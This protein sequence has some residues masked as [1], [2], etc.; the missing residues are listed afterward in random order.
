[1]NYW[2]LIQ[3]AYSGYARYLW[4]EITHPGWHSYF[5]WLIGVSAFF[6]ILEWVKP[7]RKSQARFRK[8]FWL[9]FFYMFFNFFLFSLIVFNAASNV[10]VHFFNDLLAPIGITN[11]VAFEVMSWPTWAHLLLGFFVRD[12]VQWWTHRLLHRVSFLWEFHKVH[13]SVKE[14][15]FAAHLRFHWMETVVYRTIEY[16]PLALIGI[17][18]RDFFIIHIFTLAV[19]HFNHSNFRLNL[20]PLKYIFNNPEMHIW[21]HA[22]ALPKDRF[23]GVNFGLTLSIWDYLFKTDYIPESGKD[24][25]LGFPGDEEFPQDF[26]GQ[27]THGFTRAAE[28][29]SNRHR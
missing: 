12:F 7:W 18:L 10:V 6:F 21:H 1:M 28:A 22:K 16:L 26:T 25:E 29:S 2:Q 20:G 11:L 15:G 5:Y 23:Y 24:I 19:G 17:G 14:M 8:D 27:I 13:H 3:E 4:Q 9:D